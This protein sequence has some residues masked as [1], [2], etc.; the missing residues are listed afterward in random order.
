[1]KRF[2]FCVWLSGY[3][4][5]MEE[6]WEDAVESFVQDPGSPP[7]TYT[8]QTINEDLSEIEGEERQLIGLEAAAPDLLEACE[9]ALGVLESIPA[10]VREK[11][12]DVLDEE[13]DT[14][15][16]SRAIIRAKSSK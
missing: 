16:L 4:E 14:D 10:Q 1:M 5:T 3:G 9:Y 12:A 8:V 7:D 15:R 2:E 11:I 6:A 13:I